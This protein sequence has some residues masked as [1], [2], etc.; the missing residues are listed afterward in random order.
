MTK[1]LSFSGSSKMAVG[2]ALKLSQL[3]PKKIME[4]GRKNIVFSGFNDWLLAA[5]KANG[6]SPY[7]LF[8][9]EIA[10]KYPISEA[11]A[12]LDNLLKV[13]GQKPELADQV[14]AVLMSIPAKRMPGVKILRQLPAEMPEQA[15]IKTMLVRKKILG[16]KLFVAKRLQQAVKVVSEGVISFTL[17]DGR[18]ISRFSDITLDKEGAKERCLTVYGKATIIPVRIKPEGVNPIFLLVDGDIL[19]RKVYPAEYERI[20]LTKSW[21]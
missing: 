21:R 19:V 6:I 14:Q 9:R 17:E 1:L 20:R 7:S 15:H 18:T 16:D 4:M 5:Q 12:N 13:A 8:W 10:L 11:V 2:Q 3:R